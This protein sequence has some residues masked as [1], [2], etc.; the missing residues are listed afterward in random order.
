[1]Q[2]KVNQMIEMLE[3][4]GATIPEEF[5]KWLLDGFK[6]FKETG[7]P[8]C[9]CLQLRTKGRGNIAYR[10]KLMLRN[11]HLFLAFELVPTTYKIDGQDKPLSHWQRLEELSKSLKRFE[12]MIWRHVKN[13]TTPPTRLTEQ[14]KL[15]F[16]AYKI[17]EN[18][19][20]TKQGLEKALSYINF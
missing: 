8:L 18:I 17:D 20:M 19:P 9:R 2:N 5:R 13:N 1:M 6:Q 10:E 14:E 16:L 15:I 3:N 4:P 12:V 7:K 11:H